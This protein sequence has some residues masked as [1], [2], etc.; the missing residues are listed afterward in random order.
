MG[1]FSEYFH[2]LSKQVILW[3]IKLIRNALVLFYYMS[4]SLGYQLCLNLTLHR[5]IYEAHLTCLQAMI[6]CA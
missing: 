5:R 4:K 1:L 3:L 6:S 2:F